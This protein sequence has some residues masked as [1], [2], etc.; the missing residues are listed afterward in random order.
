MQ[1]NWSLVGAYF[2]TAILIGL[3][4][5]NDVRA[6]GMKPVQSGTVDSDGLQ[7]HY[8]RSGQ[9]APILL[10]HGWGSD[11]YSNWLATDWIQRLET[12]RTV[13]AI[14]VRGHGKSDK[15]HELAP[16]SY[17]AMSG[18]VLAV[19]DAL[20][21]GKAD[22]LGYSKGAFMGAYLLGHHGDRFTSMVLGGIGDET[23]DSAAQ[24]KVIAQ[25]LRA[26]NED[27]VNSVY[28]LGVRRYV[29]ANAENDP[30]HWLIQR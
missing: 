24:G 16:Y 2:I 17:A 25:A 12:I 21:I 14:D 27:E 10:V 15:P 28:G 6:D 23:E 1:V 8:R 22:F 7:I 3:S 9:G 20:D 4:V 18:D 5:N 29:M 19:M 11:L 13:V 26:E 30:R